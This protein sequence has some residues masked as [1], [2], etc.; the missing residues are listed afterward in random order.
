MNQ[1][2]IHTAKR[3][4][5]WFPVCYVLIFLSIFQHCLKQDELGLRSLSGQHS[6]NLSSVRCEWSDVYP[7][8]RGAPR[9]VCS[10][11]ERVVTDERGFH[12][13]L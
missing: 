3:K 5:T 13:D 9:M 10:S 6:F 4:Q 11:V 7:E 8:R 2:Y 1:H 12:P